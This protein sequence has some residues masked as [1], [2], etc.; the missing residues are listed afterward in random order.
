MKTLT[1]IIAMAFL[2]GC[3]PEYP[4]VGDVLF[5]AQGEHKY[6][7]DYRSTGY[8]DKNLVY[9]VEVKES[10]GKVYQQMIFTVRFY[11]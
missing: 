5:D 2:F 9:L 1:L 10:G 7:V 4:D 3:G 8:G 6:L 11:P